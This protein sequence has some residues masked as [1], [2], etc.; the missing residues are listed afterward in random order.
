MLYKVIT[1]GTQHSSLTECSTRCVGTFQLRR[2]SWKRWIFKR[3]SGEKRLCL[4][5]KVRTEC[6]ASTDP[7]RALRIIYIKFLANAVKAINLEIRQRCLVT[8]AESKGF[9]TDVLWPTVQCFSAM[10]ISA[11]TRIFFFSAELFLRCRAFV[12]SV[13][14]ISA[15][16]SVFS[17]LSSIFLLRYCV[18]F[19]SAGPEKKCSA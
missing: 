2:S 18:F 5:S 3:Y 4:I 13:E 9:S 7:R 8:V 14:H 16:P 12:F 17:S 15:L 1:L 19:C 6:L 11:L 10:H